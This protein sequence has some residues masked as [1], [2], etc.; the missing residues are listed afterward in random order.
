MKYDDAS[1]HYGAENFSEGLPREAAATHIAMFVAW[2][3][4]SGLA[5]ELHLDDFRPE[6]E[7]LRS[8]EWTPAQWFLCVCDEKIT[9]ED[10]NEE[11]NLFAHAYHGD[12]NGLCTGEI[13][14]LDDYCAIFDAED[15]YTVPDDWTTY[16]AIAPIINQRLAAWRL[17]VSRAS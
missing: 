14:F 9:D 16:V 8:R 7:R 6:L 17:T 3:A 2:A 13:S 4:L 15:I 5:G 10:L 12:E 1:W 11:G